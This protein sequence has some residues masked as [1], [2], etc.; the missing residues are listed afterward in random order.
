MEKGGTRRSFVTSGILTAR[1]TWACLENSG[2]M[3]VDTSRFATVCSCRLLRP[4]KT[5]KSSRRTWKIGTTESFK[6]EFVA[7]DEAIC[8][9]P[10]VPDF[11]GVAECRVHPA[12]KIH[13]VCSSNS[14]SRPTSHKTSTL[15]DHQMA[16]PGQRRT[17]IHVESSSNGS[18]RS[19]FAQILVRSSE[20]RQMSFGI[21]DEQRERSGVVVHGDGRARIYPFH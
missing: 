17:K 3:K 15:R 9:L 18:S 5:Q 11:P 19:A 20:P 21:G 2:A 16:A 4:A 1:S 7:R 13:V 12:Q 8:R 14:S 6:A 10:H